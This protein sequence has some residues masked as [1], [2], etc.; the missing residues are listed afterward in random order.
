MKL[1]DVEMQNIELVGALANLI[2]HQH[3]IWDRVTNP[4]CEPKRGLC[5]GLEFSS[6]EGVDA[7]KER[8]LVALLDELLRQIGTDALGTSVARRRHTF[9]RG[10]N[11]CDS[12]KF[13][14]PGAESST[15]A[16]PCDLHAPSQKRLRKKSNEPCRRLWG[17]N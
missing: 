3:M 7:R 5:A 15:S 16:S 17:F 10:S 8:D 9:D 4:W 13:A 2:E 12:H 1:V 14:F 11:L 6:G